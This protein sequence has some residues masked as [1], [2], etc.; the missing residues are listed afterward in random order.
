[1]KKLLLLLSFVLIS[2]AL[3]A[4]GSGSGG[5]GGG[6][7]K[8]DEELKNALVGTWVS[9]DFAQDLVFEDNDTGYL[10]VFIVVSEN[11]VP[12]DTIDIWHDWFPYEIKNG[13]VS[14]EFTGDF[15]MAVGVRWEFNYNGGNSFTIPFEVEDGRVY[16]MRFTRKKE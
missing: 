6:G 11:D 15:M 13:K 9:N 7:K 3:I 1:M 5:N 14:L 8:S 4:C 16:N 10:I 12:I 2:T